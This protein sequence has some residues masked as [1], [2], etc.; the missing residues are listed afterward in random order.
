MLAIQHTISVIN[1]DYFPYVG[2]Y[3]ILVRKIIRF[4]KL[5]I[6]GSNVNLIYRSRFLKCSKQ[7]G[8]TRFVMT[9]IV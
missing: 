3:F 1:L 6:F 4:F 5:K 9:V 7:R 2:S 8:R